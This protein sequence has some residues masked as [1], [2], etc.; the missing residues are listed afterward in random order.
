MKVVA[1]NGLNN[2]EKFQTGKGQLIWLS[3]A[4]MSAY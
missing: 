3:F 1:V 4:I 2:T